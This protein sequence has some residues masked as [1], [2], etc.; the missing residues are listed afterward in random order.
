MQ[1][2]NPLDPEN[3]EIRKAIKMWLQHKLAFLTEEVI[4]ISEL[5]CCGENCPH[6]ETV[7]TIWTTEPQVFKITKPLT[8]IRKQDIDKL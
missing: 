1:F 8:Y 7:I 3:K 5:K 2:S 6:I 4:T